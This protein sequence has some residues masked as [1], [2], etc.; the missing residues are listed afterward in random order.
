MT[1]CTRTRAG[2][3]EVAMTLWLVHFN[4]QATDDKLRELVYKDRKREV[5]RLTREAGDD[6]RPGAV[7]QFDQGR[8]EA[9][10]EAQRHLNGLKWK[11]GVLKSLCRRYWNRRRIGSARAGGEP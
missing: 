1:S 4:P 10:Y 8:R 3:N 11:S 9:L 5:A 7:L 2:W 6:S